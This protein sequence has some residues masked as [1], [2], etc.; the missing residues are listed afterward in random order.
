MRILSLATDKKWAIRTFAN[1]VSYA[2]KYCYEYS[3][4]FGSLCPERPVPWSKLIHIRNNLSTMQTGEWLMWIDADAFFMNYDIELTKL[5]IP[6]YDMLLCK[7]DTNRP[8]TGVWFWRKTDWSMSYLE[9]LW[10]QTRYI[11]HPLWE[12]M[13]FIQTW[14]KHH[15]HIGWLSNKQINTF[16]ESYQDGDFIVHFAGANKEEKIKNFKYREELYA[17]D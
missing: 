5:I 16:A 3:F 17:T 4:H 11:Y 7:D 15:N 9:E 8:N 13:A 12:N 6:F 2:A 10:G 1:H 14:Q